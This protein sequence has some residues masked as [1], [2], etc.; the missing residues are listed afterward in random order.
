M[1]KIQ[2]LV[3][4]LLAAFA[5]HFS[6]LAQ[7]GKAPG[8]SREKEIA[9]PAPNLAHEKKKMLISILE[10]QET[11]WNKGNLKG[12]LSAYWNSDTLRSLSVRGLQYG[13]DRLEKKL[14]K[15]YPD[16]VSMGHLDYDVIQIE[17]IG[18]MDAMITGKWLRKNDKKFQGGFF[19]VLM[20]KIKGRWLIVSEQLS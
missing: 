12:F 16:S 19:T 1:K 11:D 13:Y 15:N 17:L 3:L 9:R 14:L 6:V 7:V 4:I 2:S 5:S 20:R 8:N 18:E 10:K